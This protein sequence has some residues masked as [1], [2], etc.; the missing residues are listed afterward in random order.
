MFCGALGASAGFIAIGC[1]APA[2][3][4]AGPISSVAGI[5]P[6]ILPTA[7]SSP[8]PGK[9][10]I[11]VNGSL[12]AFNLNSMK[13]EPITTSPK[14]AYAASPRMSHD[15]KKLVYTY[16]VVPTDPKDL[17]GSD[18]Y[19]ADGNGAN[20]H[21]LQV[22]PNAGATFEDPCW[23]SDGSAVMATMRKPIY[24]SQNQ[25][26]GETLSILTVGVAG[27]ETTP[28]VENALGPATSPDGKLL[29]FTPV[30]A[31]GQPTGLSIADAAGKGARDL[32]PNGQFSY[33]RAPEF[34]PDGSRITFAAVTGS[35]VPLPGKKIGDRSPLFDVA[36]AH[37]IPWEI[38][39]VKP[40]GSELLQLTHETE[41]TPTPTWS[42]NGDWIA[43]AGEIGLYLVDAGGKNTI[44]LST[45]V[46]GG[47]VTWF[48]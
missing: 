42:P 46:S 38:W 1:S 40:D 9:L 22:H 3:P 7:V 12:V 19:V 45:E 14:G 35:S 26:Q 39:T 11:V 8:A 44:R 43:F 41:D 2:T 24:N 33:S 32:V 18:L 10:L 30:D 31:K 34:S 36:E 23:T 16:Y 48:G 13:T 20:Q 37:G 5:G 29:V 21:L 47:G 27:G 17:G 4:A 15:R 6:V 25:Y 28:L